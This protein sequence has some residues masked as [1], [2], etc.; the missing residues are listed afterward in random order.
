MDIKIDYILL[1]YFEDS[2]KHKNI[3]KNFVLQMSDKIAILNLDF[4]F[5]IIFIVMNVNEIKDSN[6]D[7]FSDYFLRSNG[8]MTKPKKV[9]TEEYQ[10]KL[11]EMKNSIKKT[12]SS[13]EKKDSETNIAMSLYRMIQ[14][15]V[16]KIYNL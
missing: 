2:E 11:E 14:S 12:F 16:Q 15:I 5:V 13:E 9:S 4:S 6:D 1:Y 8:K 10:K 3:N 7:P